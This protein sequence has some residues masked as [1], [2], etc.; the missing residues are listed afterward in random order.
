MLC[1]EKKKKTK[2]QVRV[3]EQ[4]RQA[5]EAENLQRRLTRIAALKAAGKSQEEAEAD[6]EGGPSDA[7]SESDEEDEDAAPSTTNPTREP[8]PAPA[9]TETA[10]MGAAAVKAEGGDDPMSVD[11][12]VS[13]AK[14]KAEAPAKKP[15]KPKAPELTAAERAAADQRLLEMEAEA[16]VLTSKE[17]NEYQRLLAAGFGEWTRRDFQNFCKALETYG[18]NEKALVCAH[19]E[20][21]EAK[22]VAEYYDV[23]WKR[24]PKEIKEWAKIVKNI[25][26]GEEKL[27]RLKHIKEVL[28]WQMSQSTN[29]LFDMDLD[30]PKGTTKFIPE[31]D[32]F[33]LCAMHEVG[34]GQWE[35]IKLLIRTAYHFR[36]NWF[37]KSRSPLEINRRCD[38]LLKVK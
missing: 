27:A 26:R 31:E 33:L 20:G 11:D 38:T 36:F 25:E 17:Q 7:D 32:R 9:A 18:R 30:F 6:A 37:I 12:A 16:G 3:K 35:Q 23:F 19:V 15:G 4:K 13:K 14:V 34:Y 5:R 29:P 22:E 21:K 24:G 28:D 2:F 1:L 8:T 10:A